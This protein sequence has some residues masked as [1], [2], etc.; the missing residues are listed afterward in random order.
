M[1]GG[2]YSD[3]TRELELHLKRGNPTGREEYG[4]ES[5]SEVERLRARVSEL[6]SIVGDRRRFE[7]TLH[8]QL[9]FLQTLIDTIPNPIFYKDKH[10]TYLGCNK[11]FERRLGLGREQIVGRCASDVFPREVAARYE[12]HDAELFATPGEKIYETNLTYPD[13]QNR[14]VIVTKGIFTDSEG[15]VAGLVGVT[16]DISER[17]RAEEAL[18]KAHDDLESRVERRTA[19]LAEAVHNLENEIAERGRI[20][21]ELRVSSEKLK[22]F[23]YSVA[24]DLKSPSIGIYGL[25]RLLRKNFAENLGQKGAG[26]CEQ[27]M[28]ASEHVAS[29]V[30]AINV[31][32]ATKENPLRIENVNMAEIFGLLRDEFSARLAVRGISLVEPATAAMIRADKI[33]I[34]RVFRNLIDN[35]LKYGGD[36]LESIGI[37]HEECGAFHH[38]TVTDDGVGIHGEHGGQLFEKFQRERESEG[39]EGTG[40]GLAIIKEIAE[41]HGGRVRMEANKGG[42]TVFHVWIAKDL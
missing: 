40:L 24:H 21:E 31:F 26:I 34:L 14:D 7:K 29:L 42:G 10:G 13:G 4:T 30:D 11:A 22:I 38:F 39:I 25:T 5:E 3:N 17:K 15:A 20:A 18:Q 27:I 8:D 16:L 33:S 37:G 41:A 19:A 1:Y 12:Q 2:C 28:K 23:A 32:I 9:R 36:K 6:E 35:A